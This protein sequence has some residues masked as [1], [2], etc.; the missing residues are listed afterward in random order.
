MIGNM[1]NMRYLFLM[2][3]SVFFIACSDRRSSIE[4]D[5][6]NTSLTLSMTKADVPIVNNSNVYIFDGEGS[7]IDQF[8]HKVQR[9][10][11]EEDKLLMPLLAGVW[12]ITLITADRNIVDRII[13]PVRGKDRTLMRLWQ[14]ELSGDELNSVPELRTG[15]IQA[16]R[17]VADQP[18]VCSETILLA[19]NVAMVKVLIDD[20]AGLDVNGVH[21]FELKNVPTTLNW[22]GGLYPDKHSPE[23]GSG[24]M[25][26][27]FN[28]RN[29]ALNPGHQKSDTLKFIIPAHKGVD[30]L[31]GTPKDTTTSKLRFSID[32]ACDGGTRFQKTDIEIPRVP[33]VN[34]I[35]L[36]RLF[37]GGKVEIT[38]EIENWKDVSVDTDLNQTYLFTNKASI[39]L[40]F[41]DTISINTNAGSY[42]LTKDPSASW[43]TDI[44]KLTE[45]T[46]EITADL[47]S[48]VDNNPRTSY[49]DIKANNLT[50]RI[51]VTQRP[52]KGTIQ[53]SKKKMIFCPGTHVKESLV[54]TSRG[55]GWKLLQ[56]SSK[57]AVDITQGSSGNNTLEFIRA[58]TTNVNDF[59]SAYGDDIVVF[60]NERTLETD[61]VFLV[62]CFIYMDRNTINA[63]APSG[64][65]QTSVTT[66]QDIS[67]YGGNRDLI[68]D[69]WSSWIH[70]DIVW[71]NASQILTMTTDREP[72]D[73]PRTGFLTFRHKEC[74]DYIVTAN[75]YQDIIV[76]IPPFDYFVV[77]FTWNGND[78][79]IAAEFAR[80]SITSEGNNNSSYD[81]QPVGWSFARSVSYNA[82]QLLQWGGD[83][84]GGQGETV[85]FNAP[86]LE[87]DVNSPRK[88]DLD[89]YATWFTG[90][91]APDRMSFT[92]TA[93]KGGTM[94]QVGTNFNNVGGVNLYDKAHTVMIKTT[95]GNGSYATGGYTKVA[96]ITYDRVKHSAT[97][98]VW[99]EE[100]RKETLTKSSVQIPLRLPD[101]EKPEYEYK[102]VQTFSK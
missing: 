42:S 89:V 5:P 84:T 12:N 52:E 58:S 4:T 36:V 88:I 54:V 99:A 59:D 56:Q 90:G 39:G 45:N 50:K 38:T 57:A 80:N 71:S 69:S 20:A 30:F 86:V 92:M 72:N 10:S 19:R 48:Y 15:F 47:N 13:T 8:N 21:A 102:E 65:A 35:L 46:Y 40:S 76:T 63:A 49:I 31:S 94:Q 32:L 91:R 100:L 33:R 93:Y 85:F 25:K 81:K 60:K 77:K 74:P 55:G 75:V 23:V 78:V 68:F 27:S 96:T 73:E 70:N 53:L 101:M 83:A 2:L 41:K 67:V 24:S 43:I 87:G 66:S 26:G 3:G 22:E 18:N 17:I 95:G 79:D 28:I 44:R 7:S 62:N 1:R 61:T 9:I 29:E 14:T 97:I 16:Q 37:V 82:R 11:Y 34:G 64:G 98:K 51:P 6:Y